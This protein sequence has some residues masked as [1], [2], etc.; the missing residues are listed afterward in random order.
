MA[1]SLKLLV[2]FL[3]VSLFSGSAIAATVCVDNALASDGY[4]KFNGVK[5]PS[6]VFQYPLHMR[7]QDQCFVAPIKGDNY[8]FSIM[9]TDQRMEVGERFAPDMSFDMSQNECVRV[10]ANGTYDTPVSCN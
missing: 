4:V 5:E 1:N 10:N 2:G 9:F 8:R 7:M 6:Q 3:F